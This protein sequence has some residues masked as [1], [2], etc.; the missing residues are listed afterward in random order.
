M[1]I[2]NIYQIHIVIK[3]HQLY[4]LIKLSYRIMRN[5]VSIQKKNVEEKNTLL[6]RY[7]SLTCVVYGGVITHVN[8]EHKIYVETLSG[9]NHK[10]FVYNSL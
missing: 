6:F 10:T 4:F 2:K 3:V 9:E 8:M 7:I 1:S 5:L